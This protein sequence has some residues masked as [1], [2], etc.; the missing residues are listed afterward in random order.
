MPKYLVCSVVLAG[1][2]A[3]GIGQAAAQERPIDRVKPL[4]G[5][6]PGTTQKIVGGKPAP[7]GKY[8]FQVALIASNTP[9]DQEHFGQFCG[10]ALIAS[11]W[12]LTAAHCVPKTTAKEVDVY[13]GSTVLPAGQGGGGGM[14][15]QV[16]DIISH[17]KYVPR[18]H[19]NDI[20]LLRLTEDVPASITPTLLP[21]QAIEA[22][23]AKPGSTVT[24]IGWG[25]TSEG[26]NTTPQLMEV[27]VTMHDRAVCE[28]NYQEV[29]P[30]AAITPNMFCA[31]RTQGGADSCQGDSGGFIG[32]PSGNTASGEQ[33]MQL[34]IVSWGVGCAR[35][36][37]FGVY[38]R[39]INY[40]AWIH[41]VM[42]S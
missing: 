10:G 3:F 23:A 42:K 17:Q 1:L 16:A 6:A 22:A 28:S 31:G 9:V 33:Y 39:V 30:M 20:A 14:R 24:V 38:T 7:P 26:G 8:P 2:I 12:V 18:T 25:A 27:D 32:I 34:G 37:L 19:D 36:R 29:I 21:T 35:P 15:R 13:I 40:L 4:K 41:D 5:P 11:R